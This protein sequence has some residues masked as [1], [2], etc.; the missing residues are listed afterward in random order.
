MIRLEVEEHTDA[1]IMGF[2]ESELKV[3]KED[4]FEIDGPLDLT[5]L[6]KLY[7]IEGFDHLRNVPYIPQRNPAIE[8]GAD[9]FDEIA[10]GDIFLHHPYQTFD[11][12]VDF[13]R[14]YCAPEELRPRD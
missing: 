8:P 4:V 12:V 10:K 6:M 5:F 1:K 11:P 9:I 7:G 3:A 13:I 2:L 14:R